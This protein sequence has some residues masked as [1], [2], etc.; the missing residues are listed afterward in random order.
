MCA[1]IA[2]LGLTG[3]QTAMMGLGVA[4]TAASLVGQQRAA[5]AQQDAAVASQ[6][7]QNA[8]TLNEYQAKNE[9]VGISLAERARE[10]LRE[11][12][13]QQVAQAESG[14]AGISPLKEIA[15]TYMQQGIDNG[16]LI[17]KGGSALEQTGANAEARYQ[18]NASNYATGKAKQVNGLTAGLQIGMSGVQGYYQGKKYK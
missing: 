12:S 11:R 7:A 14:V 5:K 18:S 1:P 17:S 3:A 6:R 9:K 13:R 8:Q 4:S 15:N 2:A 10:A 16:S